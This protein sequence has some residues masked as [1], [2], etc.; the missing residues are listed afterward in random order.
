M[1]GRKEIPELLIETY[2]KPDGNCV[3]WLW[4]PPDHVPDCSFCNGWVALV[5]RLCTVSLTHLWNFLRKKESQDQ[6]PFQQ[7]GK[8]KKKLKV[9]LIMY[10]RVM[11]IILFGE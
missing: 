3:W 7:A 1:N 11:Q 4:L 10:I 2:G 8:K 6:K 9:Y 5:Y